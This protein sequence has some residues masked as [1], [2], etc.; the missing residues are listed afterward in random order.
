MK[1]PHMKCSLQHVKYWTYLT[2]PQNYDHPNRFKT[3][4]TSAKQKKNFVQI[5]LKVHN[6][7][8]NGKI[9]NPIAFFSLGALWIQ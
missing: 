2:P 5:I 4:Y 7:Q 9:E 3:Q 1:Q 8:A 6:F